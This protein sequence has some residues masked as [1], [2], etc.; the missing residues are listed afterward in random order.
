MPLQPIQRAIPFS[1]DNQRA[2][3]APLRR[4]LV[5]HH[6]RGHDQAMRAQSL[7]QFPEFRVVPR[8]RRTSPFLSTAHRIAYSNRSKDLLSRTEQGLLRYGFAVARRDQSYFES[9]AKSMLLLPDCTFA[10]RLPDREY[11]AGIVTMTVPATGLPLS[12]VSDPKG[13]IST[14]WCPEIA[15]ER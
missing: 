12:S 14:R 5:V 8:I 4:G 11:L 9:R 6:D 1:S 3:A 15:F 2:I 13:T 7:P 10:V